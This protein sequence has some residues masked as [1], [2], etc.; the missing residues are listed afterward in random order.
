MTRIERHHW[1]NTVV[2]IL[3]AAFYLSEEEQAQVIRII[4]QLLVDLRIP[5]RGAPREVPAPLSL[6]VHASFYTT[7]LAQPRQSGA[8]RPVRAATS[9]DLTVSIEAWRDALLGLITVAYPDLE[10]LE[11]LEVARTLH[12]LLAALGVPARAA[13]FFPSEVIA[14]YHRLPESLPVQ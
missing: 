4:R 7:T 12:D 8:P 5:E 13:A 6:E 3:D 10:P 11:R 14:A 2:G 1:L 9:N